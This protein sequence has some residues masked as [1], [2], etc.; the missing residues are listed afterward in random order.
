MTTAR[1]RRAQ[2]ATPPQ[3]PARQPIRPRRSTYGLV[4][5]TYEDDDG[6]RWMVLVPKGRESEASMGIVLGPPDVST[7]G[8]PPAVAFRL[9]NELFDRGIIELTD[10][11]KRT[12][13]IFAA[14]QAAYR[15]DVVRVLSLYAAQEGGDLD[16]E[17]DAR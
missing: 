10:A 15:I 5:A 13:E 4:R 17:T 11:T 9:H 8:L 1:D 12:Q 16:H 14:L 6:K 3:P 7:L 2:R